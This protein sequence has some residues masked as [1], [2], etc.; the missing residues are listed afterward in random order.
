MTTNEQLQVRIPVAIECVREVIPG[1]P[2]IV[3]AGPGVNGDVDSGMSFV[4]NV[5]H[6]H[7]LDLL[8]AT[9]LALPAIPP[10]SANPENN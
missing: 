1:R 7:T 2:L 4:T 6:A 10:S 9:I 5:C 3:I 8:K